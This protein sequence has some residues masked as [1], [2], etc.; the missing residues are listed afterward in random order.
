MGLRSTFALKFP[1]HLGHALESN[2]RTTGRLCWYVAGRACRLVSPCSTMLPLEWRLG[3]PA[4]VVARFC[5][6]GFVLFGYCKNLVSH[7]S[8]LRLFACSTDIHSPS[9]LDC[10]NCPKMFATLSA[11]PIAD[12][13]LCH[14]RPPSG[15]CG[16]RIV[17]ELS[18]SAT[19]WF[20]QRSRSPPRVVTLRLRIFSG[21]QSRDS[22]L[23]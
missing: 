7:H 16:C 14:T 18:C 22:R 2:G 5:P 20:C 11:W 6:I 1:W 12:R 10:A 17:R 19:A 13:L 21:I 3:G 23:L 8:R 4:V 15:G 9:D